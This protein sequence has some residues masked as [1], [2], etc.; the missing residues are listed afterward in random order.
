MFMNRIKQNIITNKQKTL[1]KKKKNKKQF[2]KKDKKTIINCFNLEELNI[3]I[4]FENSFMKI[5]NVIFTI[6]DF[7]SKVIF[8]LSGGV[9][10][11]NRRKVSNFNIKNLTKLLINRIIDINSKIVNLFFKGGYVSM[12]LQKIILELFYEEKKIK[13][14]IIKNI[15]PQI[16]NGIRKKNRRR[17]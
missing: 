10:E 1:N 7:D 3:Y 2:K 8:T 5:N 9:L 4:N 12:K 6:V 16:F 15:T 17:T 11:N 14:N 13:L